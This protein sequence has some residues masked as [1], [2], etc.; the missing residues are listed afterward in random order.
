[1]C[2]TCFVG[3]DNIAGGE[4]RASFYRFSQQAGSLEG[5]G[6]RVLGSLAYPFRG[7]SWVTVR[8]EAK[9]MTKRKHLKRLVRNRAAQTGEPYATALRSVRRDQLEERMPALPAATQDVIAS[10]SFCGKSTTEV[11]TLVAG[12]GVF[13]CNECVDL[14]VTIVAANAD[15]TSEQSARLRAQALDRPVPEIL[16]MLPGLA[17]SVARSEAELARWVGRL[18]D[19][20]TDW[21]QIADVL[22]TSADDARRRFDQAQPV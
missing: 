8:S 22:G 16:H 9:G 10:C 1:M 5:K 14:S 20:R 12:P 7:C 17:R 11:K 19:R 6:M 15:L 21:G 18:R 2:L 3:Q 13:I 4:F